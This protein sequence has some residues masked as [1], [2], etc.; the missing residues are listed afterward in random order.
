MNWLLKSQTLIRYLIAILVI[1]CCILI[2]ML[3]NYNKAVVE[4]SK[5]WSFFSNSFQNYFHPEDRTLHL[6]NDVFLSD[7]ME[8]VKIR[9]CP[10]CA[11]A[12][13][14]LQFLRHNDFSII[15]SAEMMHHKD[16][17]DNA[18]LQIRNRFKEWSILGMYE[19]HRR[20]LMGKWRLEDVFDGQ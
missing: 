12:E 20:S 11:T 9:C 7:A 3:Y 4:L 14:D 1:T 18:R 2:Y 6:T 10:Y 16:I 8:I 17:V 5:R 19:D 15:P 13:S